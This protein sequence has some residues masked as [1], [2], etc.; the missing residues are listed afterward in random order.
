MGRQPGWWRGRGGDCGCGRRPL[1]LQVWLSTV[2]E[3]C[4]SV[5]VMNDFAYPLIIAHS[6]AE[7]GPLIKMSWGTAGH[8][9]LYGRFEHASTTPEQPRRH[10]LQ[11]S[12]AGQDAVTLRWQSA[13]PPDGLQSNPLN[14][15]DTGGRGEGVSI[16]W[17]PNGT[18]FQS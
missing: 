12:L 15:A 17:L 1:A 8:L 18:A 6:G 9:H 7:R 3:T 4:C 14:R 10:R 16:R 5:T 11:R 2:E 13:P